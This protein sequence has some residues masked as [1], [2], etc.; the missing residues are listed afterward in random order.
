MSIHFEKVACDDGPDG[1]GKQFLLYESTLALLLANRIEVDGKEYSSDDVQLFITSFPSYN[2]FGSLIR[3]SFSS[4]GSAFFYGE[5]I[6]MYEELR[7][8]KAMFALDRLLTLMVLN[9]IAIK[10]PEKKNIWLSDRIDIAQ[11]NTVAYVLDKYGKSYDSGVLNECLNS[12]L[13]ADVELREMINPVSGI[14][15]PNS[16]QDLAQFS[17]GRKE[18][19][20]DGYELEGPQKIAINAYKW[21]ISNLPNTFQIQTKTSDGKWKDKDLLVEEFLRKIGLKA[22][23]RS[24]NMLWEISTSEMLLEASGRGYLNAIGG[25]EFI[26]EMYPFAAHSLK[27]YEHDIPLYR[28]S[29]DWRDA[30]FSQIEHTRSRLFDRLPGVENMDRKQVLKYFENE[31]SGHL[32]ELMKQFR[33]SPE[34]IKS[35]DPYLVSVGM[36]RLFGEYTDYKLFKYIKY[37]ASIDRRYEGYVSMLTD[38]APWLK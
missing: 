10:S 3:R 37:L 18:D 9:S 24:P 27:K 12:L 8:R 29:L 17:G 25:W 22:I 5:G 28:N 38:I 31:F 23:G 33:V 11:V 15:I 14:V 2:V 21:A 4:E 6:G 30:N 26:S 16:S 7:I 20:D 35:I 36:A 13:D 1:G 32:G 34:F 19:K